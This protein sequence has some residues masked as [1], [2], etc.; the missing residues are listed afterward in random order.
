VELRA[1]YWEGPLPVE[2][3]FLRTPRGSCY[4]IEGVRR[5]RPGSRSHAVFT[6]AKLDR[7]AVSDGAPG[8]HR[9]TFAPRR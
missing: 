1:L 8:V 7:D 3:D 4:L 9:W 2:G 5:T 6:V